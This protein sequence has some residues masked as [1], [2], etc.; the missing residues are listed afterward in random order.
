ME[1]PKWGT[2]DK[3]SRGV[4]SLYKFKGGGRRGGGIGGVGGEGGIGGAGGVGA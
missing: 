3:L 1:L 2:T 4:G